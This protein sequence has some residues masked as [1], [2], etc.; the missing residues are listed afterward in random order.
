MS[1]E[2][3]GQFI[4]RR[5]T[6]IFLEAAATF[7]GSQMSEEEMAGVPLAIFTGQTYMLHCWDNF[8]SGQEKKE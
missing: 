1:S 6:E 7:D 5:I 4:R 8:I 2:T 3:M